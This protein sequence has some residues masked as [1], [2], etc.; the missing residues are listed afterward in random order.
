[1][2]TDLVMRIF[3]NL[4]IA[5]PT[6]EGARRSWL[7]SNGFVLASPQFAAVHLTSGPGSVWLRPD[8]P[9]VGFPIIVVT[10]PS[11]MQCEIRS[12]LAAPELAAQKFNATVQ[13]LAMP[14]LVIRKDA[15]EQTHP[16]GGPGRYVSFRVGAAPIE[17]GGFF[18]TMSARPPSPGGLALLV[19]AAPAAP[20]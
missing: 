20:E 16:S 13:S 12:P 1:M 8:P 9:S 7:Q 18:F 15:D 11:G 2:T 5:N 3:L 19:T 6:D 10:R 17:K 4:C 14:S